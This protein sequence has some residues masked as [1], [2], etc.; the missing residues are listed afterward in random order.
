MART[1]CGVCDAVVSVDVDI[2][3]VGVHFIVRCFD[4]AAGGERVVV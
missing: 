4:Y 2:C 1:T 3:V